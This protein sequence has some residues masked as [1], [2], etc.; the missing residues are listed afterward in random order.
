[1]FVLFFLYVVHFFLYLNIFPI[2]QTNMADSFPKIS[3]FQNVNKN[4]FRLVREHR[5]NIFI[6]LHGC[7]LFDSSLFIYF[8][9]SM[10]S[11]I[12]FSSLLFISFLL[13][14]FYLVCR[15]YL[16]FSRTSSVSRTPMS[17]IHNLGSSYLFESLRLYDN[18]FKNKK[19][20]VLSFNNTFDFP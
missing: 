6:F 17:C 7:I 9:F 5:S 18:M 3:R 2:Q 12:L 16:L 1:M 10:F 14:W 8:C 11:L 20:V 15:S 13:R 4:I 19:V